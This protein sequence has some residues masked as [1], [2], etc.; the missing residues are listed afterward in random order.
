MRDEGER[1][2]VKIASFPGVMGCPGLRL[3]PEHY[4]PGHR[5]W[6]CGEGVKRGEGR[7]PMTRDGNEVKRL[8]VGCLGKEGARRLQTGCYTPIKS[9]RA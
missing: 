4:I 2:L 1:G 3:D 7:S 9:L 6:E 8:L 5:R